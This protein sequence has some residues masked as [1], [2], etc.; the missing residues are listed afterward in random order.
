VVGSSLSLNTAQG[1]GGGL[2]VGLGAALQLASG[3]LA[4]CVLAGNIAGGGFLPGN[5]SS[6]A[7]AASCA[8]TAGSSSNGG[9]LWLD[10][11]SAATVRGCSVTGNAAAASGGGFATA[12]GGAALSVTSST[13]SSN[14]AVYG[15]GGFALLGGSASL[16]VANAFVTNNTAFLGGGMAFSVVSDLTQAALSLANLTI[17][18]NSATAG[19]L[20][21]VLSGA[22]AFLV[23]SA[24]SELARPGGC[25][26][27]AGCSSVL[28]AP[29]P[30]SSM[31][32]RATRCL[33]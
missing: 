33:P 19:S 6:A 21:G 14:A 11:A 17:A 1:S 30:L 25:P 13:V 4:P 2:A 3:A 31:R 15:G 27:P 24:P 7:A 12:G 20:L 8:A 23:R 18:G 16:V 26:G 29:P 5:G 22:A 28:C 32:L 10:A 9:A